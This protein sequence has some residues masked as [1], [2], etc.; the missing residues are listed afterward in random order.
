VASSITKAALRGA[1]CLTVLASLGS[2][3]AYAQDAGS[4][5]APAAADNDVIVVTG[6][7]IARQGTDTPMP[8]TVRSAEEL[9]RTGS[10]NVG[11]TLA[12]LPQLAPTF[13]QASS[14]GGGN[15]IGTSGLDIL[16]LRNLGPARTLTLV[17]GRRHVTSIE[18]EFLV[19]VNTIPSDLIDRVDIVTGGSSAVYGSDA[20][21]GV[22]NFVLKRDFEG[23][24]AN[25]QGG[26]ASRGDR[27]TYKASATWGKNFA[28]GRGNIAASFEY[29]RALPIYY[30]ARDRQTGAYSGRNQ[31]QLVNAPGS[32]LP[33]RS[34]RHGIHSFGYADTGAFIAYNGENVRACGD[35]AAAC[36]PN[37]FPRTFIFQPDGALNESNYGVDYRP[38]GSGNNQGGSGSTLNNTGVMIPGLERYVAN[39]IG[40]YDVS[41]AFRPYFEAKFVRVISTQTSSPSF[42]QGGPQGVDEDG[43]PYDPVN[44]YTITPISINNPF[45]TPA[46]RAT[47]SSL[48]PAGAD[49]F[50]LNRNNIDL[51]SR[52][53]KDR[54]DTYRIVVGAEGTFNDDWHYDVSATYG[55]L[56]TR[57]LFSNNRIEQNFYNS[58]DAV[59]NA[60]GQIVCRVN[61]VTVTDPGCRPISLTGNQS[62]ADRAA[63]LAYFN[64]T[65][66]RWGQA[67]QFDVNA[68]LSGDLSQL[69]ELPG[70]PIRFALGGEYRRETASYHYDDLVTSGA[71]FL[72]SIQPF[73][74]PAFEVKEAFAEVEIPLLRNRPFFNELTLNGA[75]RVA[76]YKG[77]TGTVWAYNAGAVYSPVEGVRF[78]G[79]YSRSVRAPT[80]AD[81]YTTPSQDYRSV[82]DPCD[83]NFI[84]SGSST[85]AANCA[86]AGVPVGFENAVTRSQT[87]TILSGGNPDLVAE[88]SRSW[89]YG[90]VFTP[91]RGLTA[92]IDYYDVKI[93]NVIS[94]VDSQ[95][96]LNG[97]YDSPDLNNQFCNLIAPRDASGNFQIP[98]LLESTLNFAE[99]RAR[100]IDLDVRY[101]RDIGAN[102]NIALRFIGSW[103]RTRNDYPY[104][105]APEQPDRLKGELGSPIYRANVQAD[106]THNNI[107]LGYTVRYVGRQSIADWE[108]QHETA[109]V[110]DTP[111]NPLYADVTYYPKR[112]YHD[113]NIDL[114]VND[115]FTLYGGVNNLTDKLPP[116]GLLGLGGGGVDGTGNDA[117]YDNIGRFMYVGAR[118]KM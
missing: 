5:S 26:L 102:D 15:A 74:P 44:Y 86:A 97:C 100:G 2:A 111:Y 90:V 35:V 103:V 58:I 65:S 71:T 80:L 98:A 81:S 109:G 3:S 45:L 10:I 87:L 79:N 60:A 40:H 108:L 43:V 37:G 51:G 62:N 28:D 54:R 48:L 39:V 34:F 105:D 94:A 107:T 30:A 92:S 33:E 49:F 110:P 38:V 68:S 46:A 66:R 91:L 89:T 21:A 32:G 4:Q 22:V 25:V 112:V 85:R 57:Y 31:F 63:A 11:D 19:D 106:W 42:S 41:D 99:Q 59:T 20:M 56:K 88:K 1:T 61:Q 64:T 16:D 29:N 82:D 116:Y 6:S 53:E 23:L 114:K 78:R 72:N 70:G 18:G 84:N 93:S 104:L 75:G 24:T 115:N 101:T 96:I 47:I 117:L 55:K 52:G 69:F 17:N 95:D 76:D 77:A 7:R 36:L 14:L 8:V 27:G 12:Q 83:V 73:N 67:S 13:T 50:N 9:F 118:I 113:V